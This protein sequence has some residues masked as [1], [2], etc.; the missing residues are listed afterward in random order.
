MRMRVSK[1]A[2][3]VPNCTK[4][5]ADPWQPWFAATAYL[6]LMSLTTQALIVYLVAAMGFVGVIA[7]IAVSAP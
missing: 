7:F 3:T 2:S 4:K 5:P 6:W 1:A